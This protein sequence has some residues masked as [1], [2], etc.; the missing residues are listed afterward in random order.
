[1]TYYVSPSGADSGP[2]TFERPFRTLA[3]AGEALEPGDICLLRG[4]TYRET[5]RP[6]RS[7]EPEKPIVYRAYEGET[8]LISGCDTLSDW[9]REANG[10][11]SAPMPFDLADENQVFAG[12]RL[13]TEARW[14]KENGD[15][16]APARA[17]S[18]AGT[19]TTLTDPTIPGGESDWIGAVLWCAGGAKWICWAGEV[20]GYDPGA[21]TL[22][23]I[24]ETAKKH[25]YTPSP[26]SEY[27]LMGSRAALTAPGEWWFDRAAGRLLVI[28]PG[29]LEP[30]KAKIEVKSRR[31]AIDLSGR[32]YIH[33]YGLHVRGAG[34]RT[35]G[36]SCGLRFESLRGE[37]PAHSFVRDVSAHA[38]LIDGEDHVVTRCDFGYAS[39]SVVR[40]QGRHH[41]LLGNH[42]HHGNYGGMW[43]GALSL[44]GRRHVVAWNT[45]EH[46]G[47]DL[48]SIHGLTESLIEHNDL[49][50]AGWLTHD[51][52]ITYG[53]NTDFGGTIIRRNLVHD[54]LAKGLAEGIYF[55][56]CS[57]NVIV[58]ENLIWNV[59][60]M[61]VQ[62]NNPSH[63]NL[64]AHN[65]AYRTNVARP[66]ITSFDHSHRNDLYGCR[67]LNNLVNGPFRLPENAAVQ[68]NLVAGDPG[69]I[70]A[71]GGDFRLRR[72]PDAPEA[73]VPIR[74][75]ND[76]VGAGR[77]VA[78]GVPPGGAPPKAG[79]MSGVEIDESVEWAPSGFQYT[80]RL[81]NAA[82]EL[83]T[84]EG[85]RASEPGKATIVSGNGW[86]NQVAGTESAPTGTSRYEL[87]L[88]GECSVDQDVSGLPP[89][90]RF[91]LSAWVRA[92]ESKAPVL[93]EVSGPGITPVRIE[94][95][96]PEW[97]RVAVDFVTGHG[98]DSAGAPVRV[99]IRGAGAGAKVRADNLGLVEAD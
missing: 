48:V 31:E 19:E 10:I 20:T 8:P 77:I 67:F 95:R 38:V 53:H 82:F 30:G 52:G 37:Y 86:G 22:T 13:L 27:V 40:V 68:G 15:L 84:L 54:C 96:S 69:Y 42:I 59:P 60:A 87:E 90:T 64:I 14:P 9:R 39:G 73:A 56:H 34:I 41:K 23:F 49:S 61:P 18:A 58:C 51:L 55:D 6:L 76:D 85:W 36:E 29:D 11:W 74:G 45:V 70:D 72:K 21:H 99:T 78:G 93:L 33:L 89:V 7:G 32:S 94:S 92:D 75:L 98:E 50:C 25:W 62:V 88:T 16:F 65:S 81:T 26:G 2:G 80:N 44:C 57:H 28:P 43:S 3:R 79:W 1:M 71:E 17:S 5:L 47:R 46:S 66:E 91:T 24:C 97:T 35:D 12:A 63:F 83:G 4:G